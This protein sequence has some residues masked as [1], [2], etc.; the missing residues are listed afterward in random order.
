MGLR[1]TKYVLYG[2]IGAFLVSLFLIA[3]SLQ[4]YRLDF[5][6]LL[7]LLPI[8]WLIYRLILA[9]TRRDFGYLSNLCKV[10]ML[11][12]VISMIWA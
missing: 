4:N 6:F 5:I 9:D 8:A 3:L 10:I 7:L 1:R 2:L 11:L 12:G